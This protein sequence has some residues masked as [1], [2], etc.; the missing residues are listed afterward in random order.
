M[1][2][3]DLIDKSVTK[4]DHTDQAG[5]KGAVLNFWLPNTGLSQTG[6]P[7]EPPPFWSYARD[8]ILSSTIYHESMWD[9]SIYIAMTKM[10]SMEWRIK[11]EGL[12]ARRMREMLMSSDGKGWIPFL[13]RHLRD[14]L[15][16]DNGAF[17]EVVRA[18]GGAGSRILGLVHLDSRRCT[19]TGDPDIPVI[20]R[21]RKNRFHELKDY[22]VLDIVDSPDPGDLWFGVGHCAASR[23]YKAIYNLSV[24]ETYV[25]EKVAGR[26]PLAI[27]FV[28]NVSAAQ[29]ENAVREADNEAANKGYV[30]YL[31]AVV[32]PNIDPTVVPQVATIEMAGLPEGFEADNERR[33][34]YLKYANAIGLDPQDLD[35]QLLASRALG[36]G[37]QSRVIDDKASGKGLVSWRQAFTHILN[38]YIMPE[39]VT[40]YFRESDYRDQLQ[41]M[42]LE[43]SRTEV[44]AA[45]VAAGFILPEQGTQLLVDADDLPAEFLPVA[46]ITPVEE[47]SDTI[48]PGQ[49]KVPIGKTRTIPQLNSPRRGNPNSEAGLGTR[50]TYRKPDRSAAKELTYEE[51]VEAGWIK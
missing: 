3:P 6:L 41:Q 20:Y 42:E 35:P 49:V 1:P 43:S 45:R 29:I 31:G 10:A 30:A 22:E 50:A 7:P 48:N 12:R 11:G 40:F 34:A 14:Y 23:A 17:I 16:R 33:T 5:R 46:D 36:T 28:N 8:D 32:V 26:R 9:A 39:T 2:N 24:L 37:A 19:R 47:L 38:E 25:G 44:N 13:S 51:A 18:S 15:L 4:G 21:D 27:H